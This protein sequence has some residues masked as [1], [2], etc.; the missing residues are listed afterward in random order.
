MN[1]PNIFPLQKIKWKSMEIKWISIQPN[2]RMRAY[3]IIVI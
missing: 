3:M 2:E 1:P